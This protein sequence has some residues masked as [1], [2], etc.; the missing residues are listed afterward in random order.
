MK[1]KYRFG[2]GQPIGE[3]QMRALEEIICKSPDL[4]NLAKKFV[5]W[6]VRESEMLTKQ[7]WII[8][9]K[10]EEPYLEI[11][12]GIHAANSSGGSTCLNEILIAMGSKMRISSGCMIS[13]S[14]HAAILFD[15]NAQRI[16][17][18]EIEKEVESISH[19]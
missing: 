6:L 13:E 9:P 7:V 19:Q 2:I 14:P 4:P 15:G 16:F 11:I 5:I 1:R 3:E 10:C 17:Y 18:P 12:H 8:F